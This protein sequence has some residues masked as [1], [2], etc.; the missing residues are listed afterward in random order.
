MHFFDPNS[1]YWVGTDVGLTYLDRS[2]R[3]KTVTVLVNGRVGINN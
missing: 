1:V 2:F 3:F